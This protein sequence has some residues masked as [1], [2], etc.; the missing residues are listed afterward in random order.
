MTLPLPQPLAE[1]ATV[2]F[3]AANQ[4]LAAIRE[5]V[6]R[7]DPDE[8][9]IL[10]R[11]LREIERLDTVLADLHLFLPTIEICFYGVTSRNDAGQ[12]LSAQRLRKLI[13]RWNAAK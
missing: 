6:L 5:Q 9:R 11:T 7:L 8:Q 4:A 1:T 13:R 2:R 3:P 10:L 12:R